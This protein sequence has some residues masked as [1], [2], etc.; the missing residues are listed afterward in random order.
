AGL[1]CS[2]G[3][4]G[5]NTTPGMG[6]ATSGGTSSGG[7]SATGGKGGIGG[8]INPAGG[9]GGG[10]GTITDGGECFGVSQKAE[11][12]VRPVDIIMAIDNSGSMTFEAG[13]VQNNMNTFASAILNQGI[14]VHVVIIS[15]D[16]PPVPFGSNGVCIPGP[17]GSGACPNDSK[18]PI[19]QRINRGV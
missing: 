2:A 3:G 12:T 7:A 8:G 14:D 15:E 19:Y 6:G 4:S 9:V 5:S 11:N 1:A 13:E 17:L 10:G 16:G 18:P